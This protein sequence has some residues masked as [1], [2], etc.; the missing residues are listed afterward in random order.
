MI[1]YVCSR[2]SADTQEVFEDQLQTTKDI[3][4][5]LVVNGYDVIVPHLY[6]PRFLDDDYEEDR[7]IGTQSAIRLLHVCDMMFV[8]IKNKVSRGMEAE[9][10][11]ARKKNIDIFYF[12]NLNDLRDILKRIKDVD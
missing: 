6:Y 9:I 2:Y 11:A 10:I 5:V 4:R 8:Y 1:A 12:G 3:S 7:E